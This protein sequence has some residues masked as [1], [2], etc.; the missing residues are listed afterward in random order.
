MAVVREGWSRWPASESSSLVAIFRPSRRVKGS[1]VSRH[2]F[3]GLDSTRPGSKASIRS[4]SALA[5]FLPL[6]FSGR[7]FSPFFHFERDRAA[8]RSE[9]R[10]VGKEGRYGRGPWR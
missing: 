4:G 6:E 10:R 3:Q 5:C 2:R 9:E 7:D 1:T 8:D